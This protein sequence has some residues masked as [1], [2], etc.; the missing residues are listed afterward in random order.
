MFAI[1]SL[2]AGISEADSL[3]PPVAV[4]TLS[5]VQRLQNEEL[6]RRASAY[7]VDTRHAVA[8]WIKR[9]SVASQG[10]SSRPL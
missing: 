5:S 7:V 6:L 1:G 2:E 8:A 10:E 3:A 9:R 4:R